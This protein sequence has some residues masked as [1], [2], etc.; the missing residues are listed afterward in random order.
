MKGFRSILKLWTLTRHSTPCQMH[1]SLR[2]SQLGPTFRYA[3]SFS[4]F[5]PL[6]LGSWVLWL[7][8]VYWRGCDHDEVASQW[9]TPHQAHPSLK[10]KR[11]KGSLILEI[12]RILAPKDDQVLAE[13]IRLA[14]QCC[15]H[16]SIH[17]MWRLAG[18]GTHSQPHGKREES[19]WQA[20]RGLG[21]ARAHQRAHGRR[22]QDQWVREDF[23]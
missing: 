17:N 22:R 15:C 13:D 1:A 3:L 8:S 16:Q 20:T 11:S 10:G 9:D 23:A 2:I 4:Y 5:F 18:E 21:A 7:R 14:E 19:T 6:P 12:G